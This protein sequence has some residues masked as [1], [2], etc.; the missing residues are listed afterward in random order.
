MQCKVDTTNITLKK[1][2]V[3]VTLP[4]PATPE[5]RDSLAIGLATQMGMILP[6]VTAQTAT[7]RSLLYIGQLN[8]CCVELSWDETFDVCTP[9][10]CTFDLCKFLGV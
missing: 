8:G 9:S 4:N 1:D 3:A 6:I 10:T 7:S 2:G 5:E